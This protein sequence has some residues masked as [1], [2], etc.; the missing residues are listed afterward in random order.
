MTTTRTPRPSMRA[1]I[2]AKC[3]DCIHDPKAGLGAWREQVEQCPC[4]GC[5]LYPLRPLS[6]K[7]G[8]KSGQ[9]GTF[10]APASLAATDGTPSP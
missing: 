8:R 9:E 4:T 1:A 2:N 10:P 7:E 6:R 5:P 3:K